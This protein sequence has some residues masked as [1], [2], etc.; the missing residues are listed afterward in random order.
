MWKKNNDIKL[1]IVSLFII[2]NFKEQNNYEIDW[3][4][5]NEKYAC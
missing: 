1:N 3:L 2:F 4:C 5:I